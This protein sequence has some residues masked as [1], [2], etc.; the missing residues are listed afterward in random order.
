MARK[1]ARKPVLALH[2]MVTQKPGCCPYRRLGSAATE[3]R[4]ALRPSPQTTTAHLSVDRST[5]R[6][7]VIPSGRDTHI[8]RLIAVCKKGKIQ[9]VTSWIPIV[10]SSAGAAV[11]TL[12]G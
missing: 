2:G 12:L 5:H 7:A 11:V 9:T 8:I 10:I 3:L 4:Y 1:R 6:V